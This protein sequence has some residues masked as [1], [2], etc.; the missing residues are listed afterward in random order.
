MACSACAARN[1]PG[2]GSTRGRAAAP[3]RGC[4]RAAMSGGGR[5]ERD[6]TRGAP[7]GRFRTLPGSVR[8]HAAP[9]AVPVPSI[10]TVT[11]AAGHGL[12]CPA[13]RRGRGR[14]L[15]VGKAARRQ[16]TARGQAGGGRGARWRGWGKGASGRGGACHGAH[17]SENPTGP[18]RWRGTTRN[19]DP[20]AARVASKTFIA[21]SR[22][23]QGDQAVSAHTTDARR[24]RWRLRPKRSRLKLRVDRLG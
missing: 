8:T 18:A 10:V 22:P 19:A 11:H 16:G 5:T 21:P 24:S 9:H 7:T 20:A 2:A 13:H 1:R 12:R 14:H 15:C 23:S 6:R 17:K 4:S 3:P